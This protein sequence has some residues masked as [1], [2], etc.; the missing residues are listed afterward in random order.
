MRFNILSRH[1][2]YAAPVNRAVYDQMASTKHVVARRLMKVQR[3]SIE[4][5]WKRANASGSARRGL[6]DRCDPNWFRQTFLN[7]GGKGRTTNDEIWDLV[8]RF[9]MYD[10]LTLIFAVPHLAWLFFDPY[11]PS[12]PLVPSAD[13]V[14]IVGFNSEQSGLR[15]PS[16]LA[17]FLEDGLMSGMTLGVESFG[18]RKDSDDQLDLSPQTKEKHP[19][20]LAA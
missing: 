20:A 17:A 19:G 10:P 14:R 8:H 12:P 3:E 13:P 6:P 2:A 1:A 9:N 18:A 4:E 16:E 11:S 15:L 5:L 7:G